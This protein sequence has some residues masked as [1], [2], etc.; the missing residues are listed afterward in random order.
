MI[1]ITIILLASIVLIISGLVYKTRMQ[2]KKK[3]R[4][5]EQKVEETAVQYQLAWTHLEISMH[6]AFAWSAEKGILFYMDAAG[7]QGRIHLI[8]TDQVKDSR[9]TERSF[10]HSGVKQTHVDRVELEINLKDDTHIFLPV[11]NEMEDGIFE[12]AD[13]TAKARYWNELILNGKK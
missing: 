6:R 13:L 5:L 12:R 1:Y 8:H 7:G 9:V 3:R 2:V 10:L 11:Y 4:H